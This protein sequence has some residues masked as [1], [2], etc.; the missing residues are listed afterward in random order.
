MRWVFRLLPVA[1]ITTRM[2]RIHRTGKLIFEVLVDMVK[3]SEAV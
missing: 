3:W 1:S 2:K